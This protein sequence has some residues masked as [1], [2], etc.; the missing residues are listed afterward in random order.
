MS[1]DPTPWRTLRR[2]LYQ[3]A[4]G[5]HLEGRATFL[6][7]EVGPLWVHGWLLGDERPAQRFATARAAI[8]GLVRVTGF[9]ADAGAL[10][11]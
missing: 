5:T 4:P 9:S 6:I 2:G 11:A 8:S 3:P 10:P 7:E 1:L